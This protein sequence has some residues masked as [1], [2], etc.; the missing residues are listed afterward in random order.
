ME[1]KNVKDGKLKNDKG[2][3][4]MSK[5]SKKH[6]YE[7]EADELS[8]G[9]AKKSKNEK[10]LTHNLG[11][12]L[13]ADFSKVRVSYENLNGETAYT[14][15]NDI[16]LDHSVDTGT[17][18]GRQVLG[19]EMVHTAQQS[20][21]SSMVSQAPAGTAQFFPKKD[22]N[23]DLKLK[24]KFSYRND[25]EYQTMYKAY[26][27]YI[28][29]KKNPHKKMEAIKA[30]SDYMMHNTDLSGFDANTNDMKKQKHQGRMAIA[31]EIMYNLTIDDN[32]IANAE[33]NLNVVRDRGEL[34]KTTNKGIIDVVTRAVD[35]YHKGDSLEDGSRKILDGGINK[36]EDVVNGKENV[37][38]TLQTV[39]AGTL[40]NHMGRSVENLK[41]VELNKSSGVTPIYDSNGN[42]SSKSLRLNVV[43]GSSENVGATTLHELTHMANGNVYGNMME[44]S[45]AD[46][47]KGESKEDRERRYEEKVAKRTKNLD[48][49][50]DMGI[51]FNERKR[52]ML[53]NRNELDAQSIF[54]SG[55][56]IGGDKFG[57]QYA[58]Q[59]IGSILSGGNEMS[60]EQRQGIG[61][62]ISNNNIRSKEGLRKI[63]V[64]NGVSDADVRL[65]G[66]KGDN[67]EKLL[68]LM[69]LNDKTKA[70]KKGNFTTLVEYDSKLTDLL[71]QLET[72]KEFDETNPLHRRLKAMVMESF[73]E[74][75]VQRIQ[76]EADAKVEKDQKDTSTS[77]ATGGHKKK[78]RQGF[79]T[80]RG[81]RG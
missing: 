11:K 71:F 61:N 37:S 81:K 43:A 66:E 64:D 76:N 77:V 5:I 56:T 12:S 54:Y 24:S 18:F 2:G 14:K 67:V 45:I 70:S 28:K 53:D 33:K 46:K 41:G 55:A 65:S 23:G 7:Q 17:S 29:D 4:L 36:I 9:I 1:P 8:L 47:V 60:S 13:D 10:E 72:K 57:T 35:G 62:A 44:M 21:Q 63:M 40:G 52:K 20:G 15:G 25:K 27:E 78:P 49:L 38:K 59:N 39:T 69:S 68:E 42:A 73:A 32:T 31:E 34:I 6:D 30:A 22:K 48:D 75:E 74:R 19:H 16:H 3:N 50:N 58:G 51:K 80:R 26:N 79:F